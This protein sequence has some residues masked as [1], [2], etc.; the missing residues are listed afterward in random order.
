MINLNKLLFLILLAP[1][2]SAAQ[3]NYQPGVVVNLQGDTLRGL[4]NYSEWDN[5]PSSI[6]FK[7]DQKSGPLKFTANDIKYFS[8]DVGHLA[9][10]IKYIG[11]ILTD[12]TDIN[13]LSVG[14]DSSFRE[15]TV[16]LKILQQGK[17]CCFSPIRII[18][19]QDFLPHGI[20]QKNP[21]N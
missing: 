5:N 12:N 7:P 10:Y 8:V 21:L 13:H 1:F 14:R 4:I 9:A 15:D 16:F 2:F 18:R 3:D 19:K 20:F 17:N 6:S 11:P